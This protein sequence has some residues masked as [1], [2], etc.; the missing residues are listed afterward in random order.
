MP[1]KSLPSR[2]VAIA[3]VPEPKLFGAQFR[4]NFFVTDELVNDTGALPEGVKA[5]SGETI[6]ASTIDD[7]DVNRRVPRLVKFSFAPVRVV[8][9]VDPSQ[10]FQL[11]TKKA[12][13]SGPASKKMGLAQADISIAAN[14]D[15]IV[16]EDDFSNFG[17][18]GLAFQDTAIDGKLYFLASGSITSRINVGTN[19]GGQSG[20]AFS[21]DPSGMTFS[22]AAAFLNTSTPETVSGGLIE[23]ALSQPKAKGASYADQLGQ[24]V[25]DTTF[26]ELKNLAFRVQLNSSHA[27]K[28][29][30]GAVYDTT[31]IFADELRPMLPAALIAEK[32]AKQISKADVIS[33]DE[34]ETTLKYVDITPQVD[35][36]PQLLTSRIVGYVIDKYEYTGGIDSPVIPHAPIVIEHPNANRA[37]DL[38][39]KYGSMYSYSLRTVAAVEFPADPGDGTG[40]LF[41]VTALVA[42]RPTPRV[43]VKCVEDVA[44]PPP[45]DFNVSWDYTVGK[46]RLTWALPPNPQRDVKKVQV[47]KRKT[48][49]EPYQLVQMY[50]FNDSVPA[51][52]DVETP[53]A[54]LVTVS[55]SPV[56]LHIDKA[57][58]EGERWLY[59]VC[60]IDAHGM[61]SD[62]SVQFE[63]GFDRFANRIVKRVV[64][65][66]G[67]PK[68][69]PNAYLS[70]DASIDS[71]RD[72]GHSHVSVVFQPEAL[73]LF[74][75]SGNDLG[76]LGTEQ[77]GTTYRLQ[78]INV[79]F[80]K[81][82]DV[83]I[84]VHDLRKSKK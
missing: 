59:A 5:G 56:L 41:T 52:P 75:K 28:L 29:L 17:F 49:T 62:Y 2:P 78:F 50:D 76:F 47:F 22:Q 19:A 79:D 70:V 9:P 13:P 7:F 21:I 58:N 4:Y 24:Q 82:A 36:S 8:S 39:V 43:V 35:K 42:S 45:A 27:Y 37:V 55:D 32:K 40:Q 66:S 6:D 16:S 44:P 57:Y 63:V 68:A 10:S 31:S 80:Q 34:Y 71:I 11:G 23:A 83:D 33:I 30:A 73:A 20:P 1:I 84:T 14:L 38:A 69:Y 53:D 60:S 61:S 74:D 26:S 65:P 72:S 12:K 48:L 64:S 3:D 18:V 54:K 25:V 46:P 51:L 81:S 67:A 77:N 15:K